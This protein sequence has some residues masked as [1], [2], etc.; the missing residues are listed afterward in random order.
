[1]A[2]YARLTALYLIA[3]EI[4]ES[5][6]S[7]DSSDSEEEFETTT[8]NNIVGLALNIC[9]EVHPR[10]ENYRTVINMYSDLDFWRHFRVTRSTFDK[11]VDCL[12]RGG[13]RSSVIY[14][15][16]NGHPLPV[17]EMLYITLY[18]LGNQGAI[19]LI[20]DKFG[21]CEST[22]FKAISE[23]TTFLFDN[24]S[25]FIKWPTMEERIEIEKEFRSKQGFPGVCGVIDGSHI[26]IHPD[27]KNQKAY[28][29]YKK[30]H[31][32]VLMGIVLPD[33]QF[34][35]IFTGFPGIQNLIDQICKH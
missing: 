23:V 2:D 22:I 8:T 1:M 11:V 29:N 7:S 16:G 25:Q 5:S 19:R 35:Y 34:S 30:F 6:S 12:N 32:I 4:N 10:Q 13:F 28:R 17:N 14:H 18:Y 3:E 31:S 27:L 33:K 20:A 26:R 24:Q 15:G 21:H 9:H